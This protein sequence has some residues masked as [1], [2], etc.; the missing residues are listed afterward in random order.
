M[1]G[2]SAEA[3]KALEQPNPRIRLYLL[4][5]PDE[6]G[7]EALAARFGKAQGPGVERVDLD[8]PT[9]SRDP[10]RLSDEANAI[11]MFGDKRWIRVQPA[12]EES[13][14]SVEAL[15][16]NDATGDPVVLVAGNLRKNAKLLTLCEGRPDTLCI[17]SYALD[18]RSGEQVAVGMAR[19]QGL[20]LSSD[21]AR[22]LVA[23]TSGERGLLASEID[24][25]ALYLDA[26]PDRPQQ[27]T[28]EALDALAAEGGEQHLFKAAGVVLSGN[29][30]GAEHEMA[31]LKQNGGSLAGLLRLTLSRAV[32]LSQQLSGGGGGAP[33]RG[34]WGGGD[35]FARHWS[36]ETIGRAI[37]RLAEAERSGRLQRGVGETVMAQELFT[38]ARMAAR[39]R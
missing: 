8:G 25:L 26:A 1:K 6:A 32:Q 35:D 33:Q 36:P 12:G 2:D 5:G 11:S 24:K 39:G 20:G 27:A 7:S 17:V 14:S 16:G 34:N 19:E 4:Y 10:A 28:A 23:L 31:R 30:R 18:A 29:L 37:H 38:V 3:L 21:L 22:R 13:L 15:L 9:L